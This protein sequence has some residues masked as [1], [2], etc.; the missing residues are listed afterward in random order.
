MPGKENMSKGSDYN[1]EKY[2]ESPAGKAIALLRPG[3]EKEFPTDEVD[4]CEDSDSDDEYEDQ[5]EDEE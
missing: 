5:E 2:A 1:A 4:F 3:W